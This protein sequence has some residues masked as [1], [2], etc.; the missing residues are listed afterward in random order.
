MPWEASVEAITR[1]RFARKTRL[2]PTLP[3][4]PSEPQYLLAVTGRPKS[5]GT[6]KRTRD[7]SAKK[8]ST[9][10]EASVRVSDTVVSVNA[11]FQNTDTAGSAMS[12]AFRR[13]WVRYRRA[14]KAAGRLLALLSDRWRRRRRIGAAIASQ[15][16]LPAC[17]DEKL[18]ENAFVWAVS[19][20]RPYSSHDADD[21]ASFSPT[22]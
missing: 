22:T 6:R 12:S 11:R 15:K 20:A 17:P 13:R 3:H 5:Y 4:A 18:M 1:R 7:D 8:S 21:L 14:G 19:F 16:S 9:T 10:D 2:Q